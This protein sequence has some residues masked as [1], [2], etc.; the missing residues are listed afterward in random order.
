ME[1]KFS[2]L[3]QQALTEMLPK[4]ATLV[5]D[6]NEPVKTNEIVLGVVSDTAKILYWLK[7]EQ[8]SKCEV[9][10]R[11]T[12]NPEE[13]Q[14]HAKGH[15]IID[16]I[17]ELLLM[18]IKYSLGRENGEI[19]DSFGVRENWQIIGNCQSKK[20]DI[21]PKQLTSESAFSSVMEKVAQKT[22]G[23]FGEN[24][25]GSLYPDDINLGELTDYEKALD[26]LRSEMTIARQKIVDN[27]KEL[28][29]ENHDEL[30]NLSYLIDVV[31]LL[32][33]TEL[34]LRLG[35]D[36]VAQFNGVAVDK[37]WNAIGITSET[38]ENMMMTGLLDFLKSAFEGASVMVV[39][40]QDF[41]ET[42]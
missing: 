30:F 15:M 24:V 25:N 9:L 12:R 1:K 18:E 5:C 21:A 33:K 19:F 39:V 38:E 11:K 13:D 16:C 14:E 35:Y 37:N 4:V 32:F 36:T 17:D 27:N 26:S 31:V 34:A 42:N 10:C 28:S 40:P 41:D 20:E 3:I 2:D 7:K 29:T 22:S 8:V 23:V 6:I